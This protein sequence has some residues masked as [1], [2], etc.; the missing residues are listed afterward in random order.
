MLSFIR[1]FWNDEQGQSLVEYTL[2]VAFIMFTIIGL[3]KG[4]HSSI[5]GITSVTNSSL[6]A[7]NSVLH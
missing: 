2:V 4:Y 5:S 7:A 3:A 6:A 1:R